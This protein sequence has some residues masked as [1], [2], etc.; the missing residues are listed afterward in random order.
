[1][2]T[3]LVSTYAYVNPIVAVTLGVIVLD[4]ALTGRMFL[5]GGIVLASV[6]L[7]VSS[8]GANRLPEDAGDAGAGVAREMAEGHPAPGHRPTAPLDR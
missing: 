5:S 3:T 6:A 4:E 1:V 7:I 2:R 8:S